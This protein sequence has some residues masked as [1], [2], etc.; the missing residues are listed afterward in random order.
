ML[1]AS[2][3]FRNT[4]NSLDFRDQAE[5]IR[6]ISPAV[7]VLFVLLCM[8]DTPTQTPSDGGDRPH[9]LTLENNSLKNEY[10]TYQIN[11]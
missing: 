9:L 8:T 7:S 11:H 6:I 5:N 2:K 3:I 4:I 1:N 10:H